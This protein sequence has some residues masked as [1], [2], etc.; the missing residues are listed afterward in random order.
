MFPSSG[1]PI[2]KPMGPAGP[3]A[4]TNTAP[5]LCLELSPGSRPESSPNHSRFP[6]GGVDPDPTR[7]PRRE[8]WAPYPCRHAASDGSSGEGSYAGGVSDLFGSF[9]WSS[10]GHRVLRLDTR[11]TERR[12]P[13]SNQP[14]G[15]PSPTEENIQQAVVASA[16]W[17][18]Q[19]PATHAGNDAENK[20]RKRQCASD[21]QHV[22]RTTTNRLLIRYCHC[23]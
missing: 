3:V 5:N 2:K 19:V 21:V 20:K 9:L 16:C 15:L 17:G 12:P 23:C 4:T 18:R 11:T 22:A 10:L 7:I 8:R 14:K 13:L 6:E 1:G